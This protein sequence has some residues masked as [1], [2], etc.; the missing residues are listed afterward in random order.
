AA[1]PSSTSAARGGGGGRPDAGG[2]A[3]GDAR[4]PR[5]GDA[6]GGGYA[7]S[8]DLYG[9]GLLAHEMLT[10]S[11]PSDA[12]LGRRSRSR[13]WLPARTAAG[14]G[15]GAAAAA[16]GAAGG[17]LPLGRGLRRRA[18]RGIRALGSAGPPRRCGAEPL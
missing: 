8:A 13:A 3:G 4:L 15:C 1:R 11:P 2:H 6:A 17:A 9:L 10:A 12:P 18:R 7:P 5:A 14:A 16:G